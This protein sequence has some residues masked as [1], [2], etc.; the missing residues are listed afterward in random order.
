[1][2]SSQ[3]LCVFVLSLSVL[4]RVQCF[5]GDMQREKTK[6]NVNSQSSQSYE[7]SELTNE[8]Q[9]SL[10]EFELYQE[11]SSSKVLRKDGRREIN[12]IAEVSPEL[13]FKNGP[14]NSQDQVKAS[15]YNMLR[16]KRGQLK[17]QEGS[18]VGGIL[19]TILIGALGA[20]GFFAY[21]FWKSRKQKSSGDAQ[22]K[23]D[24]L[25]FIPRVSIPSDGVF[26]ESS[27][28]LNSL[29]SKKKSG[30]GKQ[31]HTSARIFSPSNKNA[32]T[33]KLEEEVHHTTAINENI[34]TN[35]DNSPR[36]SE[37]NSPMSSVR[38]TPKDINFNIEFSM[39]EQDSRIKSPRDQD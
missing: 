2:K 20:G 27:N 5:S 34:F 31:V 13:P 4:C 17:V 18:V 28:G 29:F 38:D 23:H 30:G 7:E 21:K 12:S 9:V 25:R 15:S 14:R 22:R 36:S 1:M 32:P 6:N 35:I 37:G 39:L 8:K 11:I 33:L 3:T 26:S 19:T 16:R 10:G 24:K